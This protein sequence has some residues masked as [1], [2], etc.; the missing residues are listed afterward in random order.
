MDLFK[1]FSKYNV[2]MYNDEKHK[3]TELN[4]LD[5]LII[6]PESL[7]RLFIDNRT[8]NYNL[9]IIDESESV[10]SQFFAPTHQRDRVINFDNFH[11]LILGFAKKVICLD[12]DLDHK[13]IDMIKCYKYCT[14][15]NTVKIE[16][17]KQYTILKSEKIEIVT[18]KGIVNKPKNSYGQLKEYWFRS[19]I[20]KLKAG[21]KVC[22]VS[23]SSEFCKEIKK[24]VLERMPEIEPYIICHYASGDD[25]TKDILKDVSSASGWILGRMLVYSP[26][27]GAGV[28]FAIPHYDH[29]YAYIVNSAPPK[30]FF[31]MVNRIRKVTNTNVLCLCNSLMYTNTNARLYTIEEAEYFYRYLDDT[32]IR[33]KTVIEVDENENSIYSEDIYRDR[34]WTLSETKFL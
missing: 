29:I 10:I 1:R 19:I 8:L 20:D 3:H 21:E 32:V 16:A 12:A 25:E 13:T 7:H 17:S 9:V 22:V 18:K 28:D 23:L 15:K 6:S 26:I 24:Y 11:S 31:Q 34:Y 5:R 4:I 33:K 27:I 14:M 30:T 2:E